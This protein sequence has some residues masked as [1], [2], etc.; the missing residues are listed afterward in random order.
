[1][2]VYFTQFLVPILLTLLTVGIDGSH[3]KERENNLKLTR[4]VQQHSSFQ[5]QKKFREAD[6]N[7]NYEGEIYRPYPALPPADDTPRFPV[8]PQTPY[9]P[10]RTSYYEYAQYGPS[11]SNYPSPYYT[12]SPSYPSPSA[13]SSHYFNGPCSPPTPG[14]HS[15]HPNEYTENWKKVPEIYYVPT[16]VYYDDAN[17]FPEFNDYLKQSSNFKKVRP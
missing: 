11:T 7:S 1:M 13:S 8:H 14:Y 9:S 5:N 6:F 12:E 10:P 4:V 2:C 15:H 3:L 16:T 17:D